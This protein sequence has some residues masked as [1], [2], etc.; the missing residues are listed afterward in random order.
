LVKLI[1]ATLDEER[2]RR[3]GASYAR[4]IAFVADRPGHDRRYADYD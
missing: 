3:D 4:L 1:C 2:P